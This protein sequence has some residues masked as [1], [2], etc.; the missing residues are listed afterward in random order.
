[1]TRAINDQPNVL[2]ILIHDLNTHLGCFGN[3][4]VQSPNLDRL[5][6]RG[7][8]FQNHLCNYPLCGPS[9]ASFIIVN[10]ARKPLFGWPMR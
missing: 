7:R 4:V 9:R 5:A 2:L 1:M 10:M 6:G 8:L 3:P